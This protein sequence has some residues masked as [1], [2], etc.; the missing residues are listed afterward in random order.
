MDDDDD[1]EEQIITLEHKYAATSDNCVSHEL[2]IVTMDSEN[3]PTTEQFD[4]QED[5]IVVQSDARDQVYWTDDVYRIN[6]FTAQDS[7]GISD[8][9]ISWE[10]N[11]QNEPIVQEL[12][13]EFDAKLKSFKKRCQVIGSLAAL[14]GI[15]SGFVS[16]L[17]LSQVIFVPSKISPLH[18]VLYMCLGFISLPSGDA[19]EK[20]SHL[21][22]WTTVHY[23]RTILYSLITFPLC[24]V[25]L[26]LILVLTMATSKPIVHEDKL[27]LALNPRQT[28]FSAETEIYCY[29]FILITK[30]AI[31]S[32]LVTAIKS[33]I[34][35]FTNREDMGIP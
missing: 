8:R 2:P 16:F 1:Q 25:V 14:V 23:A 3:R 30:F 28:F 7:R 10:R 33:I 4:S 19:F 17:S 15:I 6:D 9:R 31:W 22:Y 21:N 29:W 13:R 5:D 11:D 18:K 35:F 12:R 32:N 24:C 20:V 26:E 27:K 34:I